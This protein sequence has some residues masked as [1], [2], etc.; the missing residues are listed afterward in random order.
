M[1][2]LTLVFGISSFISMIPFSIISMMIFPFPWGL[3]ALP[4]PFFIIGIVLIR[5][6]DREKKK[7]D[8]KDSLDILKQR[9][10]K[11]EITK[12]EFEQKKQDLENS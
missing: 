3:F 7:L 6:Y 12:E 8:N 4:L 9:Y 1:G 11:G 2:T 10:A 5:R